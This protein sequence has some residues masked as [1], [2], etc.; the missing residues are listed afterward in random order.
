MVL[1]HLCFLLSRGLRIAKSRICSEPTE[2]LSLAYCQHSSPFCIWQLRS[3]HNVPCAQQMTAFSCEPY[4]KFQSRHTITFCHSLISVACQRI[5]TSAHHN[6]EIQCFQPQLSEHVLR[7]I[8]WVSYGLSPGWQH[9]SSN[10]T[11]MCETYK[12]SMLSSAH[13]SLQSQ[14]FQKSNPTPTNHFK[15][16]TSFRSNT[17]G[18]H[19][20]TN[21]IWKLQIHTGMQM[22]L[23]EGSSLGENMACKL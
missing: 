3:L 11:H 17:R 6:A 4:R 16:K 1:F 21:I 5:I 7:Q 22:K 13:F 14:I 23:L 8:G 9:L 2:L 10:C 15:T 18:L 20:N 12:T 19:I